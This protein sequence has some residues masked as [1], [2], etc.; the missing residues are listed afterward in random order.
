MTATTTSFSVIG[1]G[2]ALAGAG[3]AG[4]I[5][6]GV[7]PPAHQPLKRVAI[8]GT[9]PSWQ[10][11][12]WQDKTLEIWGLNDGYLLGVPRADA[13]FDLHP[14]HQMLFRPRDQRTVPQTGI[15]IGVYLR[16][17]GHLEWLKSRPI[18]VYLPEAR[19]GYP[20]GRVFPRDEVFAFWRQFWPWR[21]K[22][23]GTIEPGP[24]YEVSTPSLMLML[25]V[26][27]GYQEIYVFGISLATT[28][29]YVEQR[30]NFEFLLGV[31]IARGV[32]IVLPESAPICQAKYK[33]A[34]EPKAD[35]PLQQAQHDIATI[36]AEG[37][38]LRQEAAG[39]PWYAQGRKQ[40][41]DARLRH[42]DVVLADAK[43]TMGR[44]HALTG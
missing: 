30:P 1:A 15:P 6:C 28:W 5:P 25:A 33:Y 20:T 2:G 34:F 41:I 32:K 7:G 39:L 19:P 36:K 23:N 27:E 4:L 13:W 38:K 16:P 9:A 12:P 10:Q 21:V 26:M 17:E 22:R 11:C 44:L 37:L 40:T 35:I 31:A 29:E 3:S 42:L 43:Q 14:T 8:L 24:D 18:P